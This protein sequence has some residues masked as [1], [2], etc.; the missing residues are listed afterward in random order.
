MRLMEEAKKE[1]NQKPVPN[2]TNGNGVHTSNGD[3]SDS[4]SDI[5]EAEPVSATLVLRVVSE[6]PS[7]ALSRKSSFRRDQ[8]PAFLNEEPRGDTFLQVITILKDCFL[9]FLHQGSSSK[10]NFKQFPPRLKKTVP[11]TS[12][13]Y[14]TIILCYRHRRT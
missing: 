10:I 5:E 13:K 11:L 4:E 3:A 9:I 14:N 2:G 1:T 7:P 6:P 8:P 12:T